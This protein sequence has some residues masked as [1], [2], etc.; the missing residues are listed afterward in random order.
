MN[1]LVLLSQTTTVACAHNEI[2]ISQEEL[3]II[4]DSSKDKNDGTNT[5]I[6]PINMECISTLRRRKGNDALEEDFTSVFIE[7]NEVL[8]ESGKYCLKKTDEVEYHYKLEWIVD[9]TIMLTNMGEDTTGIKT[10][11]SGSI[12]QT[13]PVDFI[14]KGCFW[15]DYDAAENRFLDPELPN[16]EFIVRLGYIMDKNS[17]VFDEGTIETKFNDKTRKSIKPGSIITVGLNDSTKG[18]QMNYAYEF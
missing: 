18:Q 17:K 10:E 9:P 7:H 2:G 3:L 6:G 12:T 11:E 5:K 16:N 13:T 1:V 14:T 15:M 4:Y 8:K